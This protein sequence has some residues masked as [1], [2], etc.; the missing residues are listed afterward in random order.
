MGVAEAL[1]SVH[2]DI[3]ALL[4]IQHGT[5]GHRDARARNRVAVSSWLL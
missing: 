1:N 5:A 4:V 2:V 3:E